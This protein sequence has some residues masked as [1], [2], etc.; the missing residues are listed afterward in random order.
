MESLSYN[1][2]YHQHLWN[3]YNDKQCIENI[4]QNIIFNKQITL[5]YVQTMYCN[6]CLH[7][8]LENYLNKIPIEL[9]T[10]WILPFI[11]LLYCLLEQQSNEIN[12]KKKRIY[13]VSTSQIPLFLIDLCQQF[14]IELYSIDSLNTLYQ[15][16]EKE[17]S[18]HF[19]RIIE[20]L[21]VID[22]Y[23]LS[24]TKNDFNKLEQKL[25]Q[26]WCLFLT[27]TQF[28]SQ[29]MKMIEITLVDVSDSM[30]S[31]H[32]LNDIKFF[33]EPL[34]LFIEDCFKCKSNEYEPHEFLENST[35]SMEDFTWVTQPFTLSVDTID[36]FTIQY[37]GNPNEIFVTFNKKTYPIENITNPI[38]LK[39]TLLSI[40]PSFAGKYIFS[41]PGNSSLSFELLPG[42]EYSKEFQ[43]E[44]EISTG[45]I[46]TII[47]KSFDKYHNITTNELKEMKLIHNG[48]EIQLD[49]EKSSVGYITCTPVL[50]KTGKYLIQCIDNDWNVFDT[51]QFI[52]YPK[53]LN[54]Q[55]IKVTSEEQLIVS[56]MS[57]LNANTLYQFTLH[58]FDDYNNEI[59]YEMNI[60]NKIENYEEIQLESDIDNI[61]LNGNVL[62]FKQNSI[63][64]KYI[65]LQWKNSNTTLEGFP[66]SIEF[67]IP[68]ST[69][70]TMISSFY[71]SHSNNLNNIN[72][73]INS[74]AINS[75]T[76][77]NELSQ[78]IEMI[79]K[80]VTIE[81]NENILLGEVVRIKVLTEIKHFAKF[82]VSLTIRQEQ[83]KTILLQKQFGFE[84]LSWPNC[85]G[86]GTVEL[87]FDNISIWKSVINVEQSNEYYFNI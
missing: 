84:I 57:Y 82:S 72:N 2:W 77:S 24:L 69:I 54:K 26:F 76:Q 44:K 71:S 8:L 33:Y 29:F 12:P 47:Y 43:L 58:F 1:Y 37:E 86:N 25:E 70:D 41:V 27:Q 56:K 51:C 21:I 6:H 14:S 42:K 53:Q 50:Y 45:T 55:K 66:K 48:K 60:L 3:N 28:Q 22:N 80:N 5:E 36:T 59:D 68:S 40:Y 74:H 4:Q 52:V 79:K 63:G 19:E 87:L 49:I 62:K 7:N 31:I 17:Q 10:Q 13:Y 30:N 32:H 35:T 65:S 39:Q 75:P 85:K 83:M 67:S 20:I 81:M 38:P 78:L 9:Q 73:S 23:S 34:R 16:I 18:R 46:Q 61:E 15:I 11:K 64:K